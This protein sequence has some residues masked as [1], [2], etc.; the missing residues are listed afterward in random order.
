MTASWKRTSS[1]RASASPPSATGLP[2]GGR[3]VIDAAGCYVLPGLI[4]FHTHVDDRI[5]R[6]DLA[7]DYESGTRVALLNGITTLCTFV[8]QG[9]DRHPAAGPPARPA[10]KAEGRCHAD[11]AWHLTPT[12]FEA[13]TGAS[14]RPSSRAGYRTFKFYTTYR[15]AGIFADEHRLEE[16]FR[17]L[18]PL[19]V[20][21]LVHCEDDALIAA[22]DP[23]RLDLSR[24]PTHARLRPGGGRGRR[25]SR[26]SWP[27]PRAAGCRLHVVHVSTSAARSGS[28]DAR[29]PA[30]RHLRDLPPVPLA[31]RELAGPPGRPPLDLLAAPAR[32]PRALPGAGPRQGPS[33]CSPRT[34]APSGA[35]DKDDWDG[36]DVRTVANGL[37]GPRRPAPPGLEALGGRP[38]PGRPGARAPALAEPCRAPRPRR[39][40]G[41]A[42]PRPGRRRRRPRPR[43]PRAARP[44]LAGATSTR[45]TRASP[46]P[47]PSATSSLRG[48][49]RR[50]GRPPSSTPADPR[51][52]TACTR[53]L[54]LNPI[55][56]TP[57]PSPAIRELARRL[58]GPQDRPVPEGLPPHLG[59]PRPRRSRRS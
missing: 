27:W 1:W 33:T 17:R 42:A 55:M 59:A 54:D 22:V 34:T 13:A 25:P 44:L 41:C 38:R 48:R 36:Q 4:D 20:R 29:A 53:S 19:G 57:M 40:Q 43:R 8:T 51:R 14:W 11:V 16:L 21:F 37:A 30:G 52:G 18:G 6:F 35:T 47:S 28:G 39:P 10:R 3:E 56:E 31:G 23:S 46:R 49:A 15:D 24:A 26:R 7:D 5:G 9:P 32:G 2:A 12:P 58:P 45:P 50:R